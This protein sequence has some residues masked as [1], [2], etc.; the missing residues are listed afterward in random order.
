[1]A[2][3]GLLQAVVAYSASG[4]GNVQESAPSNKCLF[5]AQIKTALQNDDLKTML[6]LLGLQLFTG[7]HIKHA[8]KL[9]LF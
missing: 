3:L 8:F 6:P 1:M 2:I 9:Y 5:Y 4:G 7:Y